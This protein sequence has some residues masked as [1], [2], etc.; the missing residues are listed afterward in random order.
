MKKV[1]IVGVEGSGKTVMLACLG[2]LYSRADSMGYYLKPKNFPTA[3]YVMEKVQR[4]RHGEWPAATAEDVMQ[5][6]EWE[7]K[8]KIKGQKPIQ[9]CEVSCLDFAGEVYRKAFGINQNDADLTLANEVMAL[10]RYISDADE[11]IVLIN[12]RDV[13]TRDRGDPRVEEAWWIPKKILEYVDDDKLGHKP[14]RAAIVLSQADSYRDTIAKLGGPSEVLDK[15]LPEFWAPNNWRNVFEVSAVDK[16]ILD[17]DGCS[18]PAPDFQPIGLIPIM[19]WIIKSEGRHNAEPR[20]VSQPYR[21]F[22][23]AKGSSNVSYFAALKKPFTATGRA[24]RKEYLGFLFVCPLVFGLPFVIATV[25][26]AEFFGDTGVGVFFVLLYV[27]FG[28]VLITVGIRRAHDIGLSGWWS[29]LL[30][31]IG[32]IP[33]QREPNKYGEPIELK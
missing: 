2:E 6:L 21:S 16:T 14:T 20:S 17:N 29:L 25:T 23:L 8:R 24:S 32:L 27:Y 13:I 3:T 11:L 5:G 4:M 33:G 12:L 30:L 1:A 10:K 18:V 26:I 9:I 7:L 31:I 19:E 22:E 28:P 15:Y